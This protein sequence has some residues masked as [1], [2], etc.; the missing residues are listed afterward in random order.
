TPCATCSTTESPSRNACSTYEGSERSYLDANGEC[1]PLPANFKELNST[2]KSDLADSQKATML[3]EYA[4]KN[5]DSAK[6]MKEF[7]SL[8]NQQ[9]TSNTD[10]STRTVAKLLK[11]VGVV[12]DMPLW[13]AVKNLTDSD[14]K[15]LAETAASVIDAV[16]SIGFGLA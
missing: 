12:A 2:M 1:Q 3:L 5:F 16:D 15:D 14:A 7:T 6:S 10:S 11:T 4:Q 13:R 9:L 8:L